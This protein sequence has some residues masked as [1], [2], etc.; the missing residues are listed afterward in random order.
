MT[1]D[2]RLMEDNQSFLLALASPELGTA[3]PQLV[4]VIYCMLLHKDK[5]INWTDNKNISIINTEQHMVSAVMGHGLNMNNYMLAKLEET[6]ILGS[7]IL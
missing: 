4:F 7:W 1:L 6:V 5:I 2:F 3:Q